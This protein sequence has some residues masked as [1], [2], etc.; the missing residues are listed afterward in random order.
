M[1]ILTKAL[2]F[3]ASLGLVNIAA[4]EHFKEQDNWVTGSSYLQ[5]PS[6]AENYP[7]S[8]VPNEFKEKSP[9]AVVV[10]SQG[11]VLCSVDPPWSKASKDPYQI[12]DRFNDKNSN[13]C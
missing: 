10:P 9:W 5:G 12:A 8:A 11:P 1:N 3:G 2:L 4:A 6:R 7:S 13:R